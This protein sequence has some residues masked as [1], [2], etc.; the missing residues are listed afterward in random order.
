VEKL[1]STSYISLVSEAELALAAAAQRLA[2]SRQNLK[3]FLAEH[4]DQVA[5]PELQ[6]SWERERDVLETEVDEAQRV[7]RKCKDDLEELKPDGR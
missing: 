6:E 4:A 1:M 3:D 5:P 7:F 2:K